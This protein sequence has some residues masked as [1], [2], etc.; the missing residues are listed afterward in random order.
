[1]YEISKAD[2][3]KIMKAFTYHTPQENQIPRYNQIRDMAREFAVDLTRFCPGSR[4]LSL[5]LTHLEE[6]VMFANAAI[7]R[8]E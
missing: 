1:M 7:S 8:N 2:E 3:D 4:E 6:C 5:A